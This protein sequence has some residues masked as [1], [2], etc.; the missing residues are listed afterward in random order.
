MKKYGYDNLPFSPTSAALS[1]SGSIPSPVR[2]RL[3]GRWRQLPAMTSPFLAREGTRLLSSKLVAHTSE[4]L[5]DAPRKARP[6]R[7]QLVAILVL[8]FTFS[9]YQLTAGLTPFVAI[10][11]RPVSIALRAAVFFAVLWIL[12]KVRIHRSDI[13]FWICWALFCSIYTA[14]LIFDQSYSSKLLRFGLIEYLS[15]AIGATFLP[16]IVSVFLDFRKNNLKIFSFIF[17]SSFVA[18]FLNLYQTKFGSLSLDSGRAA[19]AILNPISFGQLGLT[20]LIMSIWALRWRR[21][22]VRSVIGCFAG[23]SGVFLSGSKGPILSLCGVMF[24]YIAANRRKIAR[25]VPAFGIGSVA[26]LGFLSTRNIDDIYIVRRISNGGFGDSIR[27]QLLSDSFSLI[28]ENPLLGGGFA[29]KVYYP[30]NILIEGFLVCGV[31]SGIP[32]LICFWI[33]LARIKV[34]A[35]VGRSSFW[36][37]LLFMQWFISSLVS[38]AIESSS[39]LFTTMTLVVSVSSRLIS[40][41]SG[42]PESVH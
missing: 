21:W 23:A 11:N 18:L 16:S 22:R 37:V 15:W 12:P 40:D 39:V 33:A 34:W 13:P 8:T 28:V 3:L 31:V 32:L 38:G 20:V 25:K 26:V 27:V 4:P 36:I 2:F 30:H 19:S 7:V 24:V 10:S 1:V 6:T 42:R 35:Q 9:G 17:H 29:T 14:R 41:R 5:R